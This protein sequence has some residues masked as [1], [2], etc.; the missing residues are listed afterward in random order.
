MVALTLASV[1]V[2]LVVSTLIAWRRP[3]DRMALI[4]ALMLVTF[5]PIIATS[6]VSA[7][8]SPWRVPNECLTFLALSLLVL[9]FL[10]FPNGQF[11]PRWMRWTLVVFLAGL[12]PE[13]FVAPF[14]P[15]TPVDQ[16]GFLVVL[17]EVAALAPSYATLVVVDTAVLWYVSHADRA[18]F[19][20][21]V[22]HHRLCRRPRSTSGRVQRGPRR[23]A[24]LVGCADPT[25]LKSGTYRQALPCR[26][27]VGDARHPRALSLRPFGGT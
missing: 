12:V 21:Q 1:V 4:V 2:C 5:G 27:V 8:P 18:R 3:D 11:V 13:I 24:A 16:L 9:V 7:S 15:N 6:S 26:S 25:E 14:M 17:G 19:V 23:L 20:D 10:L 22:E